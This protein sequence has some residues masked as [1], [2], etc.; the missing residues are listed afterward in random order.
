ML[1]ELGATV[2]KVGPKL[3]H[4]APVVMVT[5]QAEE[6]IG[7][8]SI[9]LD[10]TTEA[11]KKVLTQLLEKS[12]I[13]LANKLDPQLERLGF[14]REALDKINPRLIQLQVCARTGEQREG[15]R[16]SNWPGYD[17]ALQGKCGLMERF[18]PK[19]CP[20]F[21]GVASC[22]DYL[23]GYTTCFA[24][25]T[26]LFNRVANNTVSERAGSSLACCATLVQCS[27]QGGFNVA[28]AL[29]PHGTGLT[30]FNRI[31]Q[32]GHKE[33]PN[34][35]APEHWI[36]AQAPHDLSTEASDWT[37][38]RDEYVAHLLS[39]G[40]LTTPVNTCKQ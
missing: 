6:M 9:M 27:F 35:A 11:G 8:Q 3:P 32:V 29:G 22:V 13:A 18:G 38:T 34:D 1:A 28:S 17:P 15:V 36:Y 31:Y 10:L 25:V 16:A 30:A 7:K 24:G 26:A 21:H 39:K 14:G 40:I 33:T 23:T 2:Y 5:W 19:G 37:G 12:D 4:H 20:T